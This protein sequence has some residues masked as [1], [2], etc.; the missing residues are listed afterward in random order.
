[1]A[2]VPSGQGAVGPESRSAA[3]TSLTDSTTGTASDTLDDTTVDTKDDLAS[4]AAKINSILTALRKAGII[5][6]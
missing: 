6:S 4:L 2:S 5:A 1:M 3:I